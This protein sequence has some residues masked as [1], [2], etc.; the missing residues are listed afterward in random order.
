MAIGDDIT[1]E[2][3]FAALPENSISIKV[4]GHSEFADYNLV[5]QNDVLPFLEK[6]C[7]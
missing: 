1:D 4:G 3:M 7:N 6:L 5:K 2:D